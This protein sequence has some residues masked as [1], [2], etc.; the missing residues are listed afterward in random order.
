MECSYYN[1]SEHWLGRG[2]CTAE[3]IVDMKTAS[4]VFNELFGRGYILAE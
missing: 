4:K 1:K 3:N 2:R